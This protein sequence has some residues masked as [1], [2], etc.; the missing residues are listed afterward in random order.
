MIKPIQ[1]LDVCVL[2]II[3]SSSFLSNWL[4]NFNGNRLKNIAVCLVST[5]ED[6]TYLLVRKRYYRSCS[7]FAKDEVKLEIS[8]EKMSFSH[9]DLSLKLN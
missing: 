1:S 3:G 6:C 4:I 5:I 7:T 8:D 2:N 9:T